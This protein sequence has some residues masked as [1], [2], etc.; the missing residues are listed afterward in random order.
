MWN[1][2]DEVGGLKGFSRICL[3]VGVGPKDSDGKFGVFCCEVFWS[4]RGVLCIVL[5]ERFRGVDVGG[6]GMLDELLV[7]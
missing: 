7:L 5:L 3:E 2:C 1:L 6:E 4:D